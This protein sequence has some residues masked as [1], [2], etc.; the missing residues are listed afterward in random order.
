[1]KAFDGADE[2]IKCFFPTPDTFYYLYV[3]ASVVVE[4]APGL[5][6]VV[7]LEQSFRESVLPIRKR[8]YQCLERDLQSKGLK[9]PDALVNLILQLF[10][11]DRIGQKYTQRVSE[12]ESHMGV[13][14]SVIL[15]HIKPTPV[16]T[17]KDFM[18]DAMLWIESC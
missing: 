8:L 3:E 6:D 5:V 9:I 18:K 17:C 10:V 12:E 13:L 1:M 14:K 11:R 2:S 15:G 16:H 7:L 4:N